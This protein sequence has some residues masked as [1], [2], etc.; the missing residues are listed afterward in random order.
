M[1][2][3]AKRQQLLQDNDREKTL[4]PDENLNPLLRSATTHQMLGITKSKQLTSSGSFGAADVRERTPN[5]LGHTKSTRHL[6]DS[7]DSGYLTSVPNGRNIANDCLLLEETYPNTY[8]VDRGRRSGGG[9]SRYG[10]TNTSTS[11]SHIATNYDHRY[12]EEYN[13]PRGGHQRDY[14]LSSKYRRDLADYSGKDNTNM[15]SNSG[16]SSRFYNPHNVESSEVGISSGNSARQR[17]YSRNKTT[18]GLIS[19]DRGNEN[20]MPTNLRDRFAHKRLATTTA[21]NLSSPPYNNSLSS[22]KHLTDEEMQLLND[23]RSSADNAAILMAL[24]EDNQY[25]EAQKFQDRMRQRKELKERM[26]HYAQEAEKVRELQQLEKERLELEQKEKA[27]KEAKAK[28]ELER[29]LSEERKQKENEAKWKLAEKKKMVT[30]GQTTVADD[31]SSGSSS[32]EEED[33]DEEEEDEEEDS[34]TSSDNTCRRN[35]KV[36]LHVNDKTKSGVEDSKSNTA[37]AAAAAV[38]VSSAVNSVKNSRTLTIAGDSVV[39]SRRSLPKSTVTSTSR[40]LITNDLSKYRPQPL[41][42]PRA[43]G[44]LLNS[45]SSSALAFGGI[46]ERLALGSSSGVGRGQPNRSAYH[47]TNTA[48]RLVAAGAVAPLSSITTLNDFDLS[49]GVTSSRA[50]IGYETNYHYNDVNSSYRANAAGSAASHHQYEPYNS[51]YDSSGRR[52]RLVGAPLR[53]AGLP[54]SAAALTGY[55]RQHQRF[56]QQQQ[57]QQRH[58]QHQ[59]LILSKSATSSTISQRSRIPRTLSTFVRDSL[60]LKLIF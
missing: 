13:S 52:Q 28:E 34:D 12:P 25:L 60:F 3:V 51:I 17:L 33:E 55:Q 21:N 45:S 1:E 14:A 4:E 58:Q 56:Q 46:S 27:I 31:S 57:Q 37:A 24:R 29:K 39:D 19:D 42:L 9:H 15:Q 26:A 18:Q 30:I 35:I 53:T 38:V 7:N 16:R 59:M 5:R 49:Y 41:N 36:D 47:T 23:D 50:P 8:N 20:G 11:R 43:A 10:N 22:S 32:S 6:A 54:I 2:R 44:G 48:S 40:P